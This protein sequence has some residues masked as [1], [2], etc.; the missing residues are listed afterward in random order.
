MFSCLWKRLAC[1]FKVSSSI[2]EM[3]CFAQFHGIT[4]GSNDTSDRGT[5]S[6]RF[7][8]INSLSDIVLIYFRKK[9]L[10]C[11]N[12]D[13]F[14]IHKFIFLALISL[15]HFSQFFFTPTHFSL[16]RQMFYLTLVARSIYPREIF[17]SL[18]LL[19]ILLTSE[20]S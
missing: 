10:L 18:H 2:I 13:L 3:E 11:F 7:T 16:I 14:P 9:T 17:P 15:L 5:T 6:F 1:S 19:C 20:Q 8:V 12:P 4:G